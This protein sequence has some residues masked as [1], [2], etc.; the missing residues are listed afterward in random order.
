MKTGRINERNMGSHR[1]DGGVK[2]SKIIKTQ[3]YSN[4]EIQALECITLCRMILK[5]GVKLYGS[6]PKIVEHW[7]SSGVAKIITLENTCE[8]ARLF[9]P[10]ERRAILVSDKKADIE[11]VMNL[12]IKLY[13]L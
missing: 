8:C 7:V 2:N 11:L 6:T 12:L 4:E 3:Q 1:L 10:T 9:R 5:N 13:T